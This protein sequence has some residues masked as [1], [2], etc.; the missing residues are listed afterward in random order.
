MLYPKQV[1]INEEGMQRFL[2][3][4]KRAYSDVTHEITTANGFGIA[5][6]KAILSQI[7]KILVDAGSDAGRMLQQDIQ[8]YY[9]EGAH[10]ALQ[11]LNKTGADLPLSEGF[12]RVHKEAVEMLISDTS[13]AIAES[14]SGLYRSATNLL[15]KAVK[16]EIIN[17]IAIGRISGKTLINI[18][19]MVTG[20]IHNQ[21]LTALFDKAGRKWDLDTYAEMLIRTK[22]VEARNLGLINQVAEA[23]QDLVQVSSHNASCDLCH[24][25]EGKVL[26]LTG[27]TAGYPTLSEAESQGLF[28]PNCRHA[29]NV[30]VPSLA[31]QTS[32]YNWEYQDYDNPIPKLGK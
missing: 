21:G 12:N 29:I 27:K 14:M 6:R 17:R 3:I 25:W 1:E 4:F 5:N 16:D 24:P 31:S 30:L 28:H 15:N 22:V 23:G 20:I 18:R 26:S 10:Q 11:Q 8:G 2:Q 19:D 7:K 32:A 9:N 13:T